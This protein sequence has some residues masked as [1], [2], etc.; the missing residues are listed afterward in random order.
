[1]I[2]K[3]T[4]L[5]AVLLT[6]LNVAA[7]TPVTATA[8]AIF[9]CIYII[10]LFAV[11]SHVAAAKAKKSK[12]DDS[13]DDTTS[14]SKGHLVLHVKETTVKR[15]PPAAA[16]A[17]AAAAVTS[18]SRKATVQNGDA[19]SSPVVT[20]EATSEDVTVSVATFLICITDCIH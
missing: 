20:S 10:Q 12:A 16:A 17:A 4:A 8:T 7:V 18:R 15:A 1:M 11:I 14:G 19:P 2:A 3:D 5:H 9:M 13:K 6:V